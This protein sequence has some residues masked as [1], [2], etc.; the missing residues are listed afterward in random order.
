MDTA[1][2]CQFTDINTDNF[3]CF[4]KLFSLLKRLLKLKPLQA[5]AKILYDSGNRL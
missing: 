5:M 1:I 4:N 2:Q 3:Q